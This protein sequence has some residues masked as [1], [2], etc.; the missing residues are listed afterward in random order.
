M[1]P[2]QLIILLIVFFSFINNSTLPLYNRRFPES[3][4]RLFF[5]GHTWLLFFKLR[6]H[7]VGGTPASRSREDGDTA[8][9]TVKAGGSEVQ[10][11]A[12]EI[13]KLGALRQQGLLSEDEFR[14]G[15][16]KILSG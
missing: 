11:M 15:K 7:M 16:A 10:S 5:V 8:G 1:T 6:S 2:I 14:T 13:A 3:V 9:R 4:T 12:N